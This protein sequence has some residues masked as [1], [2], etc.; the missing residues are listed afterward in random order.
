MT[1]LSDFPCSSVCLLCARSLPRDITDY[2]RTQTGNA[3]TSFG[4]AGDYNPPLSSDAQYNVLTGIVRW[5]EEGVAPES[6]TA[7]AYNDGIAANGLN[8]TRPIC[9]VRALSYVL[10]CN[11]M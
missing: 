2:L 1:C 5:V 4:A 10:D 6:F 8:Y 9:K 3:A 7:V 11:L